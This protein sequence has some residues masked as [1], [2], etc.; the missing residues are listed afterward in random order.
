MFANT[1]LNLCSF[2]FGMKLHVTFTLTIHGAFYI[3][4]I[5]FLCY[6]CYPQNKLCPAPI[7]Y[8]LLLWGLQYQCCAL[9]LIIPCLM[10]PTVPHILCLPSS[11]PVTMPQHTGIQIFEYL[12]LHRIT[13][14]FYYPGKPGKPNQPLTSGQLEKLLSQLNQEKQSYMQVKK[15]SERPSLT[16]FSPRK[17]SRKLVTCYQQW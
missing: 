5:L 9:S 12:I 2:F 8:C 3:C 15:S 11:A 17:L 4:Q 7:L 10:P 16:S 14:C 1:P 13:A 6:L